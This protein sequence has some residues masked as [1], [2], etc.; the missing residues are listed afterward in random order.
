RRGKEDERIFGRRAGNKVG[1][2]NLPQAYGRTLFLTAKVSSL[3][4][5]TLIVGAAI[6]PPVTAGGRAGILSGTAGS[7]RFAPSSTVLARRGVSAPLYRLL[8]SRRASAEQRGKPG[9]EAAIALVI[10]G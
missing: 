6:T 9:A 3:A 2:G 1:H 7:R 10:G 5:P 8:L 4:I